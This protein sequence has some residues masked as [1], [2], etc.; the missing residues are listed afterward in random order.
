MYNGKAVNLTKSITIKFQDKFKV[1]HMM[2]SQP[3]VFSF[4]VK[5]R[6]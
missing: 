5:A 2:K 6:I 3:L 4:N 1:R